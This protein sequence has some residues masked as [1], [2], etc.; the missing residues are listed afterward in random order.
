MG[1]Y[2]LIAMRKIWVAVA[3][4]ATDVVSL[5]EADSCRK[6]DVFVVDV[7]PKYFIQQREL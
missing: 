3:K 6:G 7:A 5:C 1:E 2:T 4:R